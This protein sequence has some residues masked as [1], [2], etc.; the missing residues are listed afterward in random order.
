MLNCQNLAILLKIVNRQWSLLPLSFTIALS[1]IV[2]AIHRW[3]AVVRFIE[4][5][6][7][8]YLLYGH[9]SC[10]LRPVKLNYSR[11]FAVP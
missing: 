10:S 9:A 4:R 5:G 7:G 2:A 8:L 6:G 11:F 3:P 1:A